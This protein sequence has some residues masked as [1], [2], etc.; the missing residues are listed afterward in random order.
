MTPKF[1]LS[2]P[3]FNGSIVLMIEIHPIPVKW[4]LFEMA[5]DCKA[6]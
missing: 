3:V 6:Q 5:I 1:M 4:A 2:K